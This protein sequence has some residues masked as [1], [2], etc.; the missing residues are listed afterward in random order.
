MTRQRLD[1]RGIFANVLPLAGLAQGPALAARAR[2]A[3]Y[4]ALEAA[5]A[6]AGVLHLLLGHHAGDQ[7]ETVAMRRLAGS[8]PDGLAAMAALAETENVRLL[9]PLLMVP[10]GRLRATLRAAGQDWVEDPSNADLTTLRAR[11]RARL[12]DRDGASPATRATVA[13]ACAR[14]RARALR[15]R[16]SAALLARRAGSRPRVLRCWRPAA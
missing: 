12:A 10:P 9:R 7:A 2:R 11:L 6:A 14:G 13:G 16:A 3:R 8:G 5:C 1:R 15:E 4:A